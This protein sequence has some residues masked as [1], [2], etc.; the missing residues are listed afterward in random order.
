M[1]IKVLFCL[2]IYFKSRNLNTYVKSCNYLKILILFLMFV[3]KLKVTTNKLIG[4]QKSKKI[5]FINISYIWHMTTSIKRF[6]KSSPKIHKILKLKLEIR[7]T[8]IF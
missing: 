2:I 6:F 7:L 1:D 5:N 4:L 3:H 8:D